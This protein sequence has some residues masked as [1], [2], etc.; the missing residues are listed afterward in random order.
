V[1]QI[2]HH[3]WKCKLQTT[4]KTYQVKILSKILYPVN[5]TSSST[6][7]NQEQMNNNRTHTLSVRKYNDINIDITQ[8]T[9]QQAIR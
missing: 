7:C 3:N 2:T 8:G 1:D 9:N 5:Q 4:M 6:N